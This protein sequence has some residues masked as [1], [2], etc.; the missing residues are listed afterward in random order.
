MV[1]QRTAGPL[2]LLILHLLRALNLLLARLA[3]FLP[4]L[5][6]HFIGILEHLVLLLNLQVDS[7]EQFFLLSLQCLLLLPD[8]PQLL[9]QLLQATSPFRY[10]GSGHKPTLR[11]LRVGRSEWWS[12]LNLSG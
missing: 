1:L 12:R 8:I 5:L 2:K 6:S 10:G 11:M 3:L 9:D 7:L 4:E